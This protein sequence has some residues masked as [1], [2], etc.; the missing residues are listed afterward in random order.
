MTRHQVAMAHTHSAN[1]RAATEQAQ[2]A[3]HKALGN[4]R[5]HEHQGTPR[6][7]SRAHPRAGNTQNMAAGQG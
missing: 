1:T 5:T 4:T 3:Q 2:A 6:M 7:N